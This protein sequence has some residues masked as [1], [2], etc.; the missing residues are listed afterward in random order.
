MTLDKNERIITIIRKNPLFFILQTVGLIIL[1]LAPLVLSEIWQSVI[2]QFGVA[3][4]T[5]VPINLQAGVYSIWLAVLWMIF[6]TRFTDFY[7]DKWVLTNKRI[8]D[9]E[10]R[11]FFTRDVASVSYPKIQD[12]TVETVG[13]LATLFNFGTIQIQTAGTM[14]EFRLPLAPYPI[15][16]KELIMDLRENFMKNHQV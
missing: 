3:E 10:Q 2:S 12:A 11:G 5:L 9:I 16:K 13:F 4:N 6:V 7:L 1:A 14:Q 15:Q 8:I